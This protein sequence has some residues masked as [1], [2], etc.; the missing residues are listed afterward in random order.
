MVLTGPK[1]VTGMELATAASTAL[2]TK[3][4]FEDISEAE[5]KK[6]LKVSDHIYALRLQAR[7]DIHIGPE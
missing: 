1:L 7:I 6:V 5:A 4:E 2:K 3:M